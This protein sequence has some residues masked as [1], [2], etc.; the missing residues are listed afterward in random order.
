MNTFPLLKNVPIIAV[1]AVLAGT[2]T[3][4]AAW[5]QP[6]AG[7]RS[8]RPVPEGQVREN[9]PARAGSHPQTADSAAGAAVHAHTGATASA[10]A[11][12][13]LSAPAPAPGWKLPD[14]FGRI[15]SLEEQRGKWTL[16][17]L[18]RGLGCAHCANQLKGLSAWKA[19]FQA[20]GIDIVAIAPVADAGSVRQLE[21]TGALQVPILVDQTRAAFQAYR[22]LSTDVLHGLF[23][24][25][26]KGQIR[27]ESISPVA[28]EDINGIY[29][30]AEKTVS[31]APRKRKK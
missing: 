29:K 22:C 27:A 7:E 26:T 14:A 11:L 6:T 2:G 15:R 10:P 19:N 8:Q 25:D 12:W 20:L 16:L 9:N 28:I 18:T 24:V 30:A 31:A 4:G 5:A 23:L 3:P 1:L 21:S 17:V 13:P